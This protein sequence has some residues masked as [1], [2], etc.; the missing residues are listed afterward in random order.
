MLAE[1]VDVMTGAVPPRADGD[2]GAGAPHEDVFS[3]AESAV[4]FGA[5]PWSGLAGQ[6]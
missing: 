6:R 3:T 4:Q 5:V 1:H 2:I